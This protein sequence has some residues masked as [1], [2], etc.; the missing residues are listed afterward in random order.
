[1]GPEPAFA[2]GR[3]TQIASWS[4]YGSRVE[5]IRGFLAGDLRALISS[6]DFEG[7]KAATG[8]KGAV[9]SYLGA[10]DLW[11]ATYSD[12]SPSPKSVA[13]QADVAKMRTAAA[14]LNVLAK[15]A[16]GEDVKKEGGLFGLGAKDAVVPTGAAMTALLNEV[17][18]K[19]IA[20][21]N[22]YCVLNNEGHP[23]EVDELSEI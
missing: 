21:Y 5:A 10:L 22:D 15:K 11:A 9:G 1:M 12:S 8:K 14:E 20:A 16:T 7:I 3:A 17:R 2:R 18:D 23:F 19:A 13:M 6:G 4:R